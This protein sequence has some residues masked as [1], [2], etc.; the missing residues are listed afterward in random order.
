MPKQYGA[1]P[2]RVRKNKIEVML[3]TARDGKRWLVPKGWPMK[4]GPRYT[5]R[6]EAFEEA[7][8][9]GKVRRK[10]LGSLKYRKRVDRRRL[11]VDLKLYPLA[12]KKRVKNFPEKGERR[13]RWF[14]L[15]EAVKRCNDPALGRLLRKI[16]KEIR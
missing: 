6:R 8:V 13:L 2:F 12:V 3:A 15:K 1:V 5:A 14:S 7:G 11:N 9:K 10:P 4:R 16:K